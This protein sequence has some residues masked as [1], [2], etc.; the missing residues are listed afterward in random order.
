MAVTY[1][2]VLDR[3]ES[4]A[5]MSHVPAVPGCHTYGRSTQQ[6][7]ART[8]EALALWVE[9]AD[10]AELLPEVRMDPELRRLT[11]SVGKA[12]AHAESAQLSAMRAVRD[13]AARLTAAGLSR[14]DVATLLGV[15]HQR[16]QQ[17]LDGS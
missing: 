16:I 15:S 2:V 14:R 4:G 17:L 12:R 7:L 3:D 6:A 11:R 8:R 9:D 1:K 5:W 10:R 13:A